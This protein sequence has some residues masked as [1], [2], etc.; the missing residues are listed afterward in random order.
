[1]ELTYQLENGYVGSIWIDLCLLWTH[2]L[3]E[4]LKLNGIVG[5]VKVT[6]YGV[7]YDMGEKRT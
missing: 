7:W 5:V 3:R 6:T 4:A 1:M 2:N